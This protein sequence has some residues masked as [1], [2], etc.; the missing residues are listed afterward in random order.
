[1]VLTDA[2]LALCVAVD[3]YCR[4]NGICFL[5]ADARGVFCWL[6]CD[7][8]PAFE[9]VDKD[10]EECKEVMVG[11]LQAAPDGGK[12][13]GGGPA[14]VVSTLD[15]ARHDL[16]DGDLVCFKEVAHRLSSEAVGCPL[17]AEALSAPPGCVG[18]GAP[19]PITVMTPTTFAVHLR[20]GPASDAAAAQ[21]ASA[22]PAVVS[23][24]CAGGS[25]IQVKQAAT[26][27]FASL[28]D[29][30]AGRG[31]SVAPGGPAVPGPSSSGGAGLLV[32]P[33]LSKFNSPH[34]HTAM[35]AC[36]VTILIMWLQK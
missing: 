22:G 34:S 5:M 9:V 30:L 36:E 24:A 19:F 32:D 23:A 35:M 8:G 13:G 11:A 29:A 6:F 16:E 3:A 14:F 15:Q 4:S 10:G 28:S 21:A 31:P 25:A 33:D 2:P 17:L 1:V 20:P 7:F 27:S 18:G 26:L 12:L